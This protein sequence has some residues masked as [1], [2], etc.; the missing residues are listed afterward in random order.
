MIHESELVLIIL[1]LKMSVKH[2]YVQLREI[3]L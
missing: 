2:N 1:L 3:V